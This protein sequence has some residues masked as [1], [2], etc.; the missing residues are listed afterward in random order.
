MRFPVMPLAIA[1]LLALGSAPVS[2][3]GWQMPPENQRCPSKWG[4]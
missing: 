3:Q 2:A 1:A 4:K